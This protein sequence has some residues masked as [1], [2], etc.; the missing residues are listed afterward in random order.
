MRRQAGRQAGSGGIRVSPSIVPTFC[1]LLL[2]G[3][4]RSEHAVR[5]RLTLTLRLQTPCQNL[6]HSFP[7]QAVGCCSCAR[8]RSLSAA[9]L[10]S[11][12]HV[13]VCVCVS[14]CVS[15]RRHCIEHDTQRTVHPLSSCKTLL[16][17]S[18]L[19]DGGAYVSWNPAAAEARVPETPIS[20]GTSRKK[21]ERECVARSLVSSRLARSPRSLSFSPPALTFSGVWA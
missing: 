5:V 7:L 4:A 12:L 2:V 10:Q 8:S 15:L 13:C 18:R 20:R 11:C 6:S 3:P 17:R 21:K 14:L 9:S 1:G 16:T 19:P